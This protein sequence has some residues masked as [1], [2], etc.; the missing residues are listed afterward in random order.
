MSETNGSV[1]AVIILL[2]NAFEH[3]AILPV[4][5]V[6]CK[7]SIDHETTATK[8]SALIESIKVIDHRFRD[9]MDKMTMTNRTLGTYIDA[10][11]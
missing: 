5:Y 8:I 6:I 10:T 11:V 1:G 9:P 7:A 4:S 2:L 3:S